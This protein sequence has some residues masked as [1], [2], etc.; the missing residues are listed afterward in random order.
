MPPGQDVGRRGRC[1]RPRRPLRG[2][3]WSTGACSAR[4]RCSVAAERRLPLLLVVGR[5]VVGVSLGLGSV[6]LIDGDVLEQLLGSVLFVGDELLLAFLGDGL[7]VG[8]ALE[9][10]FAALL[11]GELRL[12]LGK[13]GFQLLGLGLDGSEIGRASCRERVS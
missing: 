7:L 5:S 9:D 1:G 8:F 2:A 13:L 3:A 11:L 12:G 4:T 10:V 6:L